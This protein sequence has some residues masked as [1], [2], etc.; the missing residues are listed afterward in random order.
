MLFSLFLFIVTQWRQAYAY[1]LS[2]AVLEQ[3]P[4]WI[5]S[6][7]PRSAFSVLQLG[8]ELKKNGELNA[9]WARRMPDNFYLPQLPTTLSP[10]IS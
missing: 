6:N 8:Y 9:E 3:A 4:N 10:K 1:V 7:Q 2:P 5:V